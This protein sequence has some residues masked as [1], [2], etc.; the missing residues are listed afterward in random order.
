MGGPS[1]GGNE[2]VNGKIVLMGVDAFKWFIHSCCKA[3]AKGRWTLGK[4]KR[5][6]CD[7]RVSKLSFNPFK[8]KI[9]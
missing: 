6:T 7:M 8:T 9:T 3:N 1:V 4:G 2:L 5:T